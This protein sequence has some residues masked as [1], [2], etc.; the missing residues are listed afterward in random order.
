MTLSR[1][2]ENGNSKVHVR[3]RRCTCNLF[4][5]LARR[6]ARVT[7][8]KSGKNIAK[9]VSLQSIAQNEDREA[10]C[11]CA[12]VVELVFGWHKKQQK[13]DLVPV[14]TF[15]ACFARTINCRWKLFLDNKMCSAT[16]VELQKVKEQLHESRVK[17][18]PFDLIFLIIAIALPATEKSRRSDRLRS[19]VSASSDDR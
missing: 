19:H 2:K 17:L 7:S 18:L 10:S 14:H 4:T 11:Q 5:S 3:A 16:L 12:R 1:E 15:F 6:S 9:C 8:I 13:S